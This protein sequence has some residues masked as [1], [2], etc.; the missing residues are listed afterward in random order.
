MIEKKSTIKGTNMSR[1]QLYNEELDFILKD[2][3]SSVR[4]A[5]VISAFIEWQV[6]SLAGNFLEEHGVVHNPEPHQEYNQSLY[7][8]EAN[9]VLTPEELGMVK[10]FRKERNKSI[11]R[12]FKDMTRLEWDRQNKLV[13]NLGRPVVKELDKKLFPKK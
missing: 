2:N 7:V 11:H 1:S 12:I 5:T 8:L 3:G 10:K 9:K 6:N 13:I 4:R